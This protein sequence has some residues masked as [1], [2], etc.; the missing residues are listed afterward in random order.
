MTATPS[1]NRSERLRTT[2]H[3]PAP[4]RKLSWTRSNSRSRDRWATCSVSKAADMP[5]L[6]RRISSHAD[7]V[8][9]ARND[10]GNTD[11]SGES[12][13]TTLLRPSEREAMHATVRSGP[14]AQQTFT[15]V[16]GR[17]TNRPTRGNATQGPW[18]DAMT[19]NKRTADRCGQVGVCCARSR[20]SPG[21]KY[22]RR[23]HSRAGWPQARGETKASRVSAQF[24]TRPNPRDP[25]T[26]GTSLPPPWGGAG[27]GGPPPKSLTPGKRPHPTP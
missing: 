1:T 24:Q 8:H 15:S 6:P 27:G 18:P 17:A 14:D 25:R 5:N 21:T 19:G 3:R 16:T 22:P 12:G 4:T 10:Q 2:C 11:S 20:L 13:P 26:H 9:R 7:P 23:R